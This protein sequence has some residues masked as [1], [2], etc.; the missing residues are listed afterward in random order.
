M[1]APR[2]CQVQFL[3]AYLEEPGIE[4]PGCKHKGSLLNLSRIVPAQLQ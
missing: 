1:A 4:G 3:V 2:V